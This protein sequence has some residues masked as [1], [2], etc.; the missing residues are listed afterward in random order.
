MAELPDGLSEVYFHPAVQRDAALQRL[1]AGY[2]HEAE[3]ATLLD[4][5][6]LGITP[7]PVDAE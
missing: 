3:L 1:K 4:R 7:I 2:E 5:S 6:L